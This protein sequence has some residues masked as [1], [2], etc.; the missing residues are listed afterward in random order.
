MEGSTKA[1]TTTAD[2]TQLLRAWADGDS[3]ALEQLTPRV[4]RELRH[5]AARLLRNERPGYTLQGTDLV[6]EVYLRLVN[7]EELNWQHRAHFFAVAAT[8]MRRILL[9][10]ARRKAAV[11]RGGK[12]QLLDVGKAVDIAQARARELVCLDDALN[13]LSAVDPRKARI[14]E[15]RFFGGLS[16]KETAE[17]VR[18][19]PDTVLRDWKIARAWLF[20]ELNSAA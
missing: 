13:A 15:L 20:A 16:V 11:K 8:L 9:D 7:A 10:R 18:V 17:V 14:V 4:Y 5:L 2:T 6:H 12:P 19:S 3:G 1:N